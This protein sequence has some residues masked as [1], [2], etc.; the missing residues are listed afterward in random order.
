MIEFAKRDADPKSYHVVWQTFRRRPLFKIPA[1]ARFCERELE[2]V[3]ARRGWIVG[4]V[5]CAPTKIHVLVQVPAR[6]ARDAVPQE[7]KRLTT[8]VVRRA[9]IAPRSRHPL[10]ER[11]AWCRILSPRGVA[12]LR[13][14]LATR[15]SSVTRAFEISMPTGVERH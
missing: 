10:W 12:I 15:T 6:V 8:A 1:A 14:H 2:R 5:H 7:L 13:H 4:R 3:A 9:G 11:D